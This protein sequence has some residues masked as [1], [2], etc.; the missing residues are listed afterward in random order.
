[1]SL[2]VT[3]PNF[4]P[5]HQT[6][7]S[8]RCFSSPSSCIT[9]QRRGRRWPSSSSSPSSWSCAS[10]LPL[11][12]AGRTTWDPLPCPLAFPS[13]LDISLGWVEWVKTQH[14]EGCLCLCAQSLLGCMSCGCQGICNW[15]CDRD[16]TVARAE[17]SLQSH[18][19]A[20]AW[21]QVLLDVKKS[22]TCWALLL[23]TSL[24]ELHGVFYPEGN[25]VATETLQDHDKHGQGNMQGEQPGKSLPED[26]CWEH[27]P[28]T[29][30]ASQHMD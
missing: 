10:L 18:N 20:K 3:P 5:S 28:P 12:S 21:A 8:L 27:Q 19:R 17:R 4:Q 29:H 16:F 6:C 30:P 23:L 2:L 11:M 22:I 24:Q 26:F 13:L 1:M 9:R 14:F 15:C 25:V 7:L